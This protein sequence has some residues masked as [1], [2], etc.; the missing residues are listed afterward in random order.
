[1][2]KTINVD[3]L[4]VKFNDVDVYT[5][6]LKVKDVIQLAYVAVRNVDIEEGSVQRV[7]NRTRI[8]SI[9]N[10]LLNGNI[11][12][13][14]FIL[15]WTNV[16]DKISFTKD[17]I[18]IPLTP[19]SAQV[20]DGQ[21]R[22]EGLKAAVLK[23]PEIGEQE[24]IVSITNHLKTKDAARI[25]LNIN[26]E[27]KPVPKSLIYDLFG[28]I[29]DDENHAINRANDIVS[30]LN[31]ND[32]SPYYRLIKLPG[33]PRGVGIVDLATFISSIK[34]DLEF[35]GIYSK[36]NINDLEK[37]KKLFLNFFSGIY[38]YYNAAG[39]WNTKTKNPFMH[40]SGVVGAIDFLKTTL[41]PMC[42]SKKSFSIGTFIN[43]LKLD[44]DHLLLQS[45]IKNSDGKSARNI[46]KEY[47]TSC[48]LTDIPEQSEYDF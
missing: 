29:E 24:I 11:F 21:H 7:L 27:Q 12:Y 22:L 4:K 14:T 38:H 40:S 19:S 33:M 20:I 9:C 46:V 47:L 26:T 41:L 45:D 39:I 18:I 42:V 37:Q 1:M 36:Y 44:S 30:E 31:T 10:Y 3:Y 15:N 5:Q 28:E 48:L 43:L 34:S 35:N 6:T 16:D 23:K 25:F 8:K 13:N 2:V 17:K 32:S